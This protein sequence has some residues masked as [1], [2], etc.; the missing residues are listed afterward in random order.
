MKR[1]FMPDISDKRL[2][3]ARRILEEKGYICAQNENNS[4]FT[5][6]GVN[7]GDEFLKD[8][9]PV[10]AGNVNKPGVFDYTKDESFAIK[11]AYLTAEA[12][13][14]IAIENSDFSL[15][16]SP[17]LICGYGRIGKA[18]EDLLGAFTKDITVCARKDEQRALAECR[19]SKTADFE[20]L[21][22]CEDYL[23]IFNTVPHPV[24]SVRELMTVNKEALL[25]DLASFPG[26]VDKHYAKHFKLNFI[27]ARGLPAKY[28]PKIAGEFAAQTIDKIIKEKGL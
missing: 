19:G 12:A 17:V 8:G 9:K 2:E 14:A 3:S 21:L 27:E 5:V 4:D 10:F 25:I 23:F 26:G 7:P 16:N 24:F 1:F 18:L 13:I 28:S 22:H 11:N 20:K 15:I 6:L